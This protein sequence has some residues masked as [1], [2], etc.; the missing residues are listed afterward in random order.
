MENASRRQFLR[1]AGFGLGGFVLRGQ[2]Q[3]TFSTEVKV[4]NVL[5]TVRGKHGE[6]VRDLEKDGFVLS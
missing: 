1:A 5:A 6:I 2:D 3:P 4:V